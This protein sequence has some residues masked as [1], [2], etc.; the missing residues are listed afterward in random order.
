MI[1]T[2]KLSPEELEQ[3][4]GGVIIDATFTTGYRVCDDA[5]GNLLC[6]AWSS[7]DAKTLARRHGVSD[8]IISRREYFDKYGLE[9][10][11]NI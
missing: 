8:Q 5:T 7:D 11:E 10:H 2:G 9:G 3:V 6:G 1:T 4:N